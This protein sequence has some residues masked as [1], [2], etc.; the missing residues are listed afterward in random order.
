LYVTLS[1]TLFT[2]RSGLCS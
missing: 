1:I 2:N